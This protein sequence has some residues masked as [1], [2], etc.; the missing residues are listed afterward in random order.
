MVAPR[1]LN[2]A[3]SGQVSYNRHYMTL[4]KPTNNDSLEFPL[5]LS[6][7]IMDN[8]CMIILCLLSHLIILSQ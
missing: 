7:K 1:S 6:L 2:N 3:L 8:T 4:N 5:F